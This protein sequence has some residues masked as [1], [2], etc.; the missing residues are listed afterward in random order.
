MPQALPDDNATYGTEHYGAAVSDALEAHW[1]EGSDQALLNGYIPAQAAGGTL[2]E[3]LR[4]S[5][6]FYSDARTLDELFA[7]AEDVQWYTD[8]EPDADGTE[9][10]DASWIMGD[11]VL[12]C[13]FAVSD[14]YTWVVDF[15]SYRNGEDPT[16]DGCYTFW[17][18]ERSALLLEL[19][20]EN[21]SEEPSL[22]RQMRGAWVDGAGGA[23]LLD[24]SFFD[25]TDY[26]L[27]TMMDGGVQCWVQDDGS[28]IVFVLDETGNAL[29]ARWY[30]GSGTQR[31]E[32][33]FT[34]GTPG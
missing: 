23:V 7:A 16:A 6:M 17:D 2:E 30:D 3:R 8:Y 11:T 34:R 12:V 21:A 9:Y 13:V 19:Y 20:G 29:T 32:Q 4:G 1:G 33:S 28:Y 25:G 10:A 14:T 24:E 27:G 22:A 18:E 31:A 5:H 26:T 15:Y